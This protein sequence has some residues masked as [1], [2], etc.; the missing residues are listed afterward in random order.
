[1]T[2][3]MVYDDT[4]QTAF[5]D[6]GYIPRFACD[7][8]GQLIDDPIEALVLWVVTSADDAVIQSVF[9]VHRGACDQ[10]LKHRLEAG[11]GVT[12]WE[13]LAEHTLHLA[14]NVAASGRG[15][16]AVPLVEMTSA[17]PLFER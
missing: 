12:Y 9:H 17:H 8:C 16:D 6:G 3:R 2:V 11:G 7:G 10:R 4:L 13:G 15:A 1:M 14:N 5:G